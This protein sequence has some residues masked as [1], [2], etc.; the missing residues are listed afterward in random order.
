MKLHAWLSRNLA[1]CIDKTFQ[2]SQSRIF[3]SRKRI[4]WH[5]PFS[6]IIPKS[7]FGTTKISEILWYVALYSKTAQSPMAHSLVRLAKVKHALS[8][9]TT[10][11][12]RLQIHSSSSGTSSHLFSN[13]IYCT[14]C[15]ICG[16]LYTS[17]TGKFLRVR[18]G[19]LR[20]SVNN[21]N[22]SKPLARHFT[23]GKLEPSVYLRC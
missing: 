1:I 5:L 9:I 18:F 22:N 20:T 23:S 19:E 16:Q 2:T 6:T 14:S 3:M 21:N 15:N 11:L 13:V 12:S 7:L 4:P 17:E 8:P 10:P